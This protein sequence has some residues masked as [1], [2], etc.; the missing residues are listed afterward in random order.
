[1]DEFWKQ[2]RKEN[3]KKDFLL[4]LRKSVLSRFYVS[5]LYYQF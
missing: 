4:P 3:G 1:M 5:V 2:D